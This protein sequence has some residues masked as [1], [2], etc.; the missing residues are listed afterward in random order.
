MKIAEINAQY[1]K[2]SNSKNKI[3]EKHM[4]TTRQLA[5]EIAATLDNH[6]DVRN[7][8]KAAK[9]IENYLKGED[10]S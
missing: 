8:L 4:D 2:L 3:W 6:G 5:L 9:E 7:L 1:S 10:A